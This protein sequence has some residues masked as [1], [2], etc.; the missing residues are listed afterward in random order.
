MSFSF[1]CTR[2]ISKVSFPKFVCSHEWMEWNQI[3][4]RTK[5][6]VAGY[7]VNI[8][9][10]MAQYFMRYQYTNMK[11]AIQTYSAVDVRSVIQY[12]TVWNCSVTEIHEKLCAVY[13]PQCMSPL[14]TAHNFLC[15]C[16]NTVLYGVKSYKTSNF[17]GTVRLNR[18]LH[19]CVL[20]SHEVLYHST[21][22][23]YSVFSNLKLSSPFNL[24]SFRSCVA[25]YKFRE[26]S[27]EM[28]LVHSTTHSWFYTEA[29]SLFNQNLWNFYSVAWQ[30]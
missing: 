7:T 20:V 29:S 22:N 15:I 10:R 16:H 30:V 21:W 19:V 23:V 4:G 14:Y 13:K 26:T 24:V 3:S 9:R 6:W 25:V 27:F 28:T 8:S 1:G 5:F 12:F 17:Q 18:M 2:V 11:H